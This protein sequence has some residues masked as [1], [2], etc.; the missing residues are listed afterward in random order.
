MMRF[1]ERWRMSR[2]YYG[3]IS[4]LSLAGCQ[5]PYLEPSLF[6]AMITRRKN[7]DKHL[8]AFYFQLVK[9]RY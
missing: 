2:P 3:R 7:E 1:G 4:P 5:C 8:I 9:L 6:D